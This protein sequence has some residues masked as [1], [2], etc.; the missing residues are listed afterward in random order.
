MGIRPA[1]V[2]LVPAGRVELEP[3]HSGRGS[4][5][6]LGNLAHPGVGMSA[7]RIRGKLAQPGVEVGPAES[8]SDSVQPNQS[9]PAEWIS[10]QPR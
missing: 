9:I 4:N 3:A 1:R 10:A 2:C 8:G 6:G 5:P 7:G